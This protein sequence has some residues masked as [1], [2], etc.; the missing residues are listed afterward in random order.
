MRLRPDLLEV[1]ELSE[2]HGII[3]SV[4]RYYK[5]PRDTGRKEEGSDSDN[6]QCQAGLSPDMVLHLRLEVLVP[7]WVIAP[8]TSS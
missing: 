7:V 3:M 5:D 6:P 2:R 4:M 1:W 8:D